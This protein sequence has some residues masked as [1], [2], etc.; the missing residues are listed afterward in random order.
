MYG[1][2]QRQLNCPAPECVVVFVFVCCVLCGVGVCEGFK[3]QSEGIFATQ[4]SI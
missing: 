4:V 3:G 2:L 1:F